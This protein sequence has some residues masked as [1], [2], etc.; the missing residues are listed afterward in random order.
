MALSKI[1][2][3]SDLKSDIKRAV[4]EIG[5]F[6]KYIQTGNTVLVKPNFNT[7]DEPPASTDPAFLS[8]VID[9]LS[10][11]GAKRI[12]IGESSTFYLSTKIV[13]EQCDVFGVCI[14]GP[15]VEVMVFENH[16]YVKKPVRGGQYL[17]SVTVPKVLDEVDRI[18]LLPCMKTHFAAQYTGALKI[19][20][21]MMKPSE[22]VRMHMGHVPEKVA[23]INLLYE[24]D[25]AVMDGRKCFIAG[26]PAKGEVREPGIILASDSRVEI[27][28]EEV[29]TIQS[30]DGNSLAGI[31][32]EEIVQIKHARKL[33]IK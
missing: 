15:A 13:L 31:D 21:G 18:V 28:L 3:G 1:P 16:Q 32:P 20:V 8:A 9:L 12:V 24:P 25:L 19:A 7:A 6:G 22:R 29:R 33:G 2:T 14:K 4:D 17:R 26:G 30:F 11:V 23:E 27:D 10:E 5:G